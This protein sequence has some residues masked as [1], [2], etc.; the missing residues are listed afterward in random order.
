LLPRERATL[1]KDLCHADILTASQLQTKSGILK[2]CP[3]GYYAPLF[4]H[5]CFALSR[6]WA[7]TKP[8]EN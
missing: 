4:T 2:A 7:C 6:L 3:S 1:K 8:V 5:A